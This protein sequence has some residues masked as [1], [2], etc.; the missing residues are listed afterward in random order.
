[1]AFSGRVSDADGP[2]EG[3]I[4]LG[5]A[6][7]DAASGGQ[8]LWQEEHAGVAVQGGLFFVALGSVDP[9][10]PLD[11]AVFTGAGAWL[12]LSVNG[13]VQAPRVAIHS[14]PYAARAER[15]DRAA[16]ADK[17][18]NLGEADL[19][20]AVHGHDAADVLQLVDPTRLP[21]GGNLLLFVFY[22]FQIP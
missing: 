13:Q 1:M 8:V 10:R 12:E 11:G 19:A 22:D 3:T 20:R 7:Y 4:A 18:G 17:I 21:A 9:Q 16:T 2:I 5:F 6:L 14:V 15:A